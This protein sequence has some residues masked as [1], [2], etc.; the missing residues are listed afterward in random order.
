MASA[1][2]E[3]RPVIGRIDKTGRL[4]SADPQLEALQ[5]EAGSN[6]AGS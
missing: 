1:P 2:S 3:P 6:V 5:R 4:V